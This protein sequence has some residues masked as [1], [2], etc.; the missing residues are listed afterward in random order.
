MNRQK[1]LDANFCDLVLS[2]KL[3]NSTFFEMPVDMCEVPGLEG[4]LGKKHF[5]EVCVDTDEF[6]NILIR[7][8]PKKIPSDHNRASFEHRLKY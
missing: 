6:D 4:S 3:F 8:P 7:Q 5:S 1:L 2:Q